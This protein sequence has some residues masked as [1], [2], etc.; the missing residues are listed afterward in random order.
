ME[1][2]GK[3]GAENASWVFGQVELA[4]WRIKQVAP[5]TFNMMEV[6][7]EQLW[8]SSLGAER[9]CLSGIGA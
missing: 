9:R 1:D 2:Q 8:A 6:T 3:G 7:R 4:H 5:S